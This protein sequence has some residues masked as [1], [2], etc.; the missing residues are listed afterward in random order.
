MLNLSIIIPTFNRVEDLKNLFVSIKNQRDIESF[1]FEIHNILLKNNIL[2]VE[3]LCNIKQ[4][5]DKEFMFFAF[6]LKVENG[7]A[8]PIRAAAILK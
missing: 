7:D 6:P 5:I 1:D 3:N 8:S 2:I 4:L